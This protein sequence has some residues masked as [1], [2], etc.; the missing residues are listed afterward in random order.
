MQ[1]PSP[2]EQ[3]PL[4]RLIRRNFSIVLFLLLAGSGMIF[5][6]GYISP[7]GEGAAEAVSMAGVGQSLSAPITKPVAS[8]PV[9]QRFTQ[10]SAPLRIGI[11]VGHRGNDSGAVCEDGLTE[12][13]V[14]TAI[15]EKTL[16][17]LE[18]EGLSAVLLDEFDSRLTGFEGTVLVS[19]HAD[20]CEDLGPSFSGFKVAGSSFTDSSGLVACLEGQYEAA[21]GL[22]I[23]QNTVTTHM[24]DYHAF[25]EIAPGTPAAIVETGFLNLDRSL[26]TEDSDIPASGKTLP[27]SDES[28]QHHDIHA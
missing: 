16:L 20:S 2:L 24:T 9:R 12:L 22:S 15:A 28:M 5:L 4:W 10:T 27:G 26:L 19:I 1:A 3:S 17:R 7:P 25:R 8:R 18:T 11:I 23:H 6:H 21:T 13:A 14:N